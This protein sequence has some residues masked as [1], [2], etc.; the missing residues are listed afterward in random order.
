MNRSALFVQALRGPVLL[1]TIGI[2]FALEQSGKMAF[3]RTW[4][5]II[6]V[7]GLMKL[8]ERLVAPPSTFPPGGPIR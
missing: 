3:T 2:L 6:I 8:L 4:P 1:I 5:L 7:V